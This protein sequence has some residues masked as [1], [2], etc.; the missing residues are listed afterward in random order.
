MTMPAKPTNRSPSPN[1]DDKHGTEPNTVPASKVGLS[2]TIS[3]KTLK[4]F[5]RIQAET[6]KD[7]E[8]I[9]KFSWR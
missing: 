8:E 2:L 5:D 4:E 3:N 6:T 7:V 9:Q 1:R